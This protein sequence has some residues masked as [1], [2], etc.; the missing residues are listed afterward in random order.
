MEKFFC[1]LFFP[2]GEGHDILHGILGRVVLF[3]SYGKGERVITFLGAL[4]PF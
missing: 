4:S 2:V 3:F 1:F